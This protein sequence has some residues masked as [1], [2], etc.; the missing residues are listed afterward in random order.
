M[1]TFKNNFSKIL[2]FLPLIFSAQ[3]APDLQELINAGLAKNHLL[4]HQKLETKYTELD[5]EKLKD[6]FLPKLEISG[7]FGYMNTTAHLTSPEVSIPKVPPVFP[8]MTVPEN[9]NSYN[10]SGFSGSAKAE[11]SVLLYS[12]GK[13][14][15][16]NQALNEKKLS[17]TA[18]M[19]KTRDEV[20]TEISKAYD[21]F[22]LVHE[23]KK[24]L[25]ESKK[26]LDINKKTADKALGYGLITPYDHKKI[27]LAQANLDSK[28]V[29]YEG[30]KE[31][32]ITQ[33]QILTGLER[34][35]IAQI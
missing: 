25:D 31:L 3:T 19:Q 35:K 7:K 22:A 17:E 4:E 33:L 21:Q 27:E 32:L 1:N 12:G 14:K 2:V 28:M 16:L 23:S 18:L 26:R 24:V 34:E 11:A 8:G 20:I 13:V 30:K 29:E 5:Q 6:I 15:Y 10:V 9:K